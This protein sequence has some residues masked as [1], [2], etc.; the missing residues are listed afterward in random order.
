MVADDDDDVPGRLLWPLFIAIGNY[1][2]KLHSNGTYTD[3]SAASKFTIV[4][5]STHAKLQTI[6]TPDFNTYSLPQC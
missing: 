5:L 6:D 1:Y 3:H 4:D 2:D